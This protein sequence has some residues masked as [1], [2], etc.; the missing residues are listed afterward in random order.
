MLGLSCTAKN[1]YLNKVEAC[2]ALAHSTATDTY[3]RTMQVI[4]GTAFSRAGVVK[5][6]M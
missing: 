6:H 4:S 3:S 5:Y 1:T 2:Q